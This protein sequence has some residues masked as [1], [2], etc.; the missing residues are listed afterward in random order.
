MVSGPASSPA[1][2]SSL[3]TRTMRSTISGARAPGEVLGRRERGSVQRRT[4]KD[5]AY[6]LAFAELQRASECLKPPTYDQA[7]PAVGDGVDGAGRARKGPSEFE[8]VDHGADEALGFRTASDS[9][10]GRTSR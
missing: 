7:A 4:G 5:D 1:S 6:R 3:R 8:G 10:P 9:P 2:V